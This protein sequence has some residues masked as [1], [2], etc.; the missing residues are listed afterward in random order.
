MSTSLDA[1]LDAATKRRSELAAEVQR[2]TGRLE[3]AQ[4]NLDDIVAECREKGIEPEKLEETIEKLQ[5]R[6]EAE[7][8]KLEQQ[9]A[10]A[11][12]ALEPFMK[13]S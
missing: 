4:R 1:R 11:E 6:Y 9:V 7:V 5:Q 10:D 3:A 2:I 8:E 13:E 12:A